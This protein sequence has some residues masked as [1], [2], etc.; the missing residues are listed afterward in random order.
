MVPLADQHD[1]HRPPGLEGLRRK[2]EV[3]GIDA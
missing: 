3:L 1:A 2:V